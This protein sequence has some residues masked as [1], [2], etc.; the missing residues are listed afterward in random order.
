VSIEYVVSKISLFEDLWQIWL[1]MPILCPK[2]SVFGEFRPLNIIGHYRSPQ[3]AL[4][5][6]KPRHE[7]SRVKIVS[8]V[9]AVGDKKK[10][11]ERKGTKSRS[12]THYISRNCREA[13]CKRILTKFCTSRDMAELFTYAKFSVEKVR[14][15]R[16]T[17]VQTLVSSIETA[18]PLKRRVTLTTVLR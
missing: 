6:A 8:V 17:E 7:P 10:G 16:Y 18:F 4:P 11:K 13:P 3:K 15:Y 14:G 1:K 9:F 2:I 5:C 12:Q